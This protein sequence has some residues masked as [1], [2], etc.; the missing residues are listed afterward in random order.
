ME[1]ML[2]ADGSTNG[3]FLRYT[4]D[5]AVSAML[6]HRTVSVIVVFPPSVLLSTEKPPPYFC[7]VFSVTVHPLILRFVQDS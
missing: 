5:P 1:F 2:G 6:L 7:A 3:D 4:S